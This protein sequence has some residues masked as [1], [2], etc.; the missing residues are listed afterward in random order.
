[1]QRPHEAYSQVAKSTVVDPREFDASILLKAAG[2]FQRIRD[3][4]A[5]G[6]RKELSAALLYNRKIWTIY[7]TS[8]V[9]E[10]NPLPREIR[11]NLANLAV[12]IF[13]HTINVEIS[14]APD[15]LD[16]LININRNIA[17]GLLQKPA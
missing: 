6:N 1:M 3:E 5:D 14:P 2:R 16:V 10:S 15:M 12:F 13:K 17:A 7:A 11:Q 8:V 4:W 9:E